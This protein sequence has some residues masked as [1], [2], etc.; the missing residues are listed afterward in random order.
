MIFYFLEIPVEKLEKLTKEKLEKEIKEQIKS[1][2]PN[3]LAK[4]SVS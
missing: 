1:K 2:P 3:T 4:V